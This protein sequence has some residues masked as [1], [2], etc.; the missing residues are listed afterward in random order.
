MSTLVE[1][2]N[3]LPYLPVIGYGDL[4]GSDVAVVP[5]KNG[6]QSQAMMLRRFLCSQ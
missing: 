5:F 4:S 2:N 6:F 3:L 1:V